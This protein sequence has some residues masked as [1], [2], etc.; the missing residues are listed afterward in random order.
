MFLHFRDIISR[1]KVALSSNKAKTENMNLCFNPKI[2][3]DL[4]E[5]PLKC[6]DSTLRSLKSFVTLKSNCQHSNVVA[7]YDLRNAGHISGEDNISVYI[8]ITFRQWPQFLGV[9]VG[10]SAK[11]AYS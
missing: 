8:K 4:S 3:R 1:R 11:A 9:A 7:D 5:N 6:N 2:S 10:V